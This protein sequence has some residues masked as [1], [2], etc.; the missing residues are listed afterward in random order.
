[1]SWF[2]GPFLSCIVNGRIC[3]WISV[4]SL[5]GDTG[6]KGREESKVTHHIFYQCCGL[7]ARQL[8]NLRTQTV[9]KKK[10]KKFQRGYY[11]AITKT[12]SA[13]LVYWPLKTHSNASKVKSAN[14]W[15]LLSCIQELALW[16]CLFSFVSFNSSGLKSRVFLSFNRIRGMEWNRIE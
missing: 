9:K 3:R 11:V 10:R 16:E 1:M 4:D 14:Q 15:L 12:R 8:A 7:P 6:D 13:Y 5:Q 2:S